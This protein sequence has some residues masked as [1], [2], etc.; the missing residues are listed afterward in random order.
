M[1]GRSGSSIGF[2]RRSCALIALTLFALILCPGV[3]QAQDVIVLPKTDSVPK[4]ASDSPLTINIFDVPANTSEGA[5]P[6][7][8]QAVV[9]PSKPRIE[10][11]SSAAKVDVK[12]A[13]SVPQYSPAMQCQM[14]ADC[15]FLGDSCGVYVAINKKYAHQADMGLPRCADKVGG[16]GHTQEA[17]ATM[18]KNY[19]PVCENQL[20]VLRTVR[21]TSAF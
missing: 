14:D 6:D 5:N 1:C 19:M 15:E 13:R 10:T 2:V 7:L 21:K 18:R 17:V 12:A 16:S 9:P 8:A 3:V 11:T 4:P 20:C